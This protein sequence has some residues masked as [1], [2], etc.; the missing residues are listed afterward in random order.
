MATVPPQQIK[1]P[2]WFLE[3]LEGGEPP[4]G[5]LNKRSEPRCDAYLLASLH[6]NDAP[7]TKPLSVKITNLSSRGI[8]L[9]TRAQLTENQEFQLAP[10]GVSEDGTP[11]ESVQVRVVHC[12]RTVQGYKVGCILT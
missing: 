10:Q 8:G 4:A 3:A 7:E 9:I 2:G 11:L 6:P 5:V 12:T 1:L